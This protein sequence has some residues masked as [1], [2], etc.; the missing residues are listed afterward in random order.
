MSTRVTLDGRA[1]LIPSQPHGALRVI[2]DVLAVNM[3]GHLLDLYADDAATAAEV[4][5]TID[6]AMGVP[7]VHG[8][9]TRRRLH[10]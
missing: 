2:S 1:V 9:T 5:L 7:K 6:A 10:S 4:N 3:V 8:V